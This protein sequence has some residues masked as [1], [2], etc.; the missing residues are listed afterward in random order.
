MCSD[1]TISTSY[2]RMETVWY[3]V[4]KNFMKMHWKINRGGR[5]FFYSPFLP[6]AML[7]NM[8]IIIES[9][10]LTRLTL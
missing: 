1:V 2:D 3:E 10:N 5:F 4:E 8:N 6:Y 9:P 7:N